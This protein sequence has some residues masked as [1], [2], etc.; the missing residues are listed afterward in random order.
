MMVQMANEWMLDV[1]ADLKTFANRNGLEN[2][3]RQLNETMSVV[4]GELMSSQEIAQGTARRGMDYAG[5][6]LRQ[7]AGCRDS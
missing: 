5:S 7:A 3:E 6:F 2:T 1:L 4:A